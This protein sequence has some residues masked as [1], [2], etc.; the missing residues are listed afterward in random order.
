M[1][2]KWC[3]NRRRFFDRFDL[4]PK[5]SYA[6]WKEVVCFWRKGSMLFGKGSYALFRDE[7]R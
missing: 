5:R 3:L 1:P 2:F 4:F 6:F 7:L